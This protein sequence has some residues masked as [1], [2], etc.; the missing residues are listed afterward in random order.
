MNVDDK[1]TTK[2]DDANK[3]ISGTTRQNDQPPS[4]RHTSE[5]QGSID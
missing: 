5:R 1:N 4:Q 3:N 2:T